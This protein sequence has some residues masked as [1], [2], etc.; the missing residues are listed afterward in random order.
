MR[1]AHSGSSAKWSTLAQ[2]TLAGTRG[3][4]LTSQI[5]L[6]P[7]VAE[8]LSLNVPD[9]YVVHGHSLLPMLRGETDRVRECAHTAYFGFPVTVTDGRRV[10]HKQPVRPGNDPLYRYG[11]NLE[12]FQKR[13]K[14]PYVGAET[15][16]LLPYTDATVFRVP[17]H[18][19]ASFEPETEGK[20][21]AAQDLLFDLEI[22]ED[23]A[24]NQAAAHP[25]VATRLKRMLVKDFLRIR[26]PEEQYERLG[27]WGL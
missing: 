17:V 21:Q 8:A 27:L 18:Q 22:G 5:D 2:A 19:P 16:E 7:T 3:P 26:A 20:G 12:A 10:L 11:I 15:G 13:S 23:D 6:Y 4:W 14:D 25:D 1:V 9:D 24:Q